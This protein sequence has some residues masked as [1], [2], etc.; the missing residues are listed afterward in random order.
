[1]LNIREKK[2]VMGPVNVFSLLTKD[3]SQADHFVLGFERCYN[4]Q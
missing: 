4:N 1:M 3:F 2:G